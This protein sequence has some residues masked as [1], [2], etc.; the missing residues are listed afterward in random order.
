MCVHVCVRVFVCICA[1]ECECAFALL[2]VMCAA[3]DDVADWMR[4]KHVSSWVAVITCEAISWKA[5]DGDALIS[6]PHA[7]SA[8]MYL[9]FISLRRVKVL[10]QIGKQLLIMIKSLY[11]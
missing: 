1:F 9:C 10:F 11:S 3:A 8:E 4:S 7:Q 2:S 6:A 5:I